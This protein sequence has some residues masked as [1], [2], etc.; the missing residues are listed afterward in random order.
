MYGLIIILVLV[1]IVIIGTLFDNFEN[2]SI[3]GKKD[4]LPSIKGKSNT[5][6]PFISNADINNVETIST[7]GTNGNSDTNNSTSGGYVGGTN[8]G[9]ILPTDVDAFNALKKQAVYNHL[10]AEKSLTDIEALVNKAVTDGNNFDYNTHANSYNVQLASL[11]TQRND[12]IK[13]AKTF[14]NEQKYKKVYDVRNAKNKIF[15]DY[16]TDINKSI[17]DINADRTIKQND[18]NVYNGTINPL[19]TNI[20][21]VQSKFVN[22]LKILEDIK[23]KYDTILTGINTINTLTISDIADIQKQIDDFMKDEN[24]KFVSATDNLLKIAR[25]FMDLQTKINAIKTPSKGFLAYIFPHL[26]DESK[27]GV[28]DEPE[29]LHQQTNPITKENYIWVDYNP[30][31]P[32]YPSQFSDY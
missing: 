10:E 22:E 2:Y 12:V 25:E 13:T 3:S 1:V 29:V 6:E 31:L 4:Y 5:T 14:A 15:V 16:L 9:A 8:G 7:S 30:P 23:D 19:I 26:F 11:I 21:G 32:T 20:T 17:T 27:S 28:K 24:V 18:K